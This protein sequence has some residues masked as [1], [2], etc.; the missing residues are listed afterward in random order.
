LTGLE[1]VLVV[2]DMQ[3][4]FLNAHSR[5]ILPN[6]VQLVSA[7]RDRSLPIIFTKFQNFPGSPFERL[8]NWKELHSSDPHIEIA[9]DLAEF[10]QIEITKYTYTAMT[11]DMQALIENN[12]WRN[13]VICGIATESCVLKTAI[14]AF[15]HNLRPLVVA[16]SCASDTGLEAHTAGIRVLEI[17]IGK[18]Q[19]LD[20]WMILEE[21]SSTLK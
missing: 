18:N 12:Q 14:D 6:V 4:G 20:T 17:T 19:I 2:I 15:E 11:D 3:D 16:D 1:T 5:H 8:L 7:F 13:L 10:I 21:L 9:A